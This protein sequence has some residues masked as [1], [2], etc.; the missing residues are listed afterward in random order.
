M[1]VFIAIF[2]LAVDPLSKSHKYVAPVEL[3]EKVA[4]PLNVIAVPWHTLIIPSACAI[5]A[6]LFKIEVMI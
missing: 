2:P 4:F 6:V 5:G 1:N 3:F